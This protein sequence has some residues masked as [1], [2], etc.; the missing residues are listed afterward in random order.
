[1]CAHYKGY[2]TKSKHSFTLVSKPPGF[3]PWKQ[4]LLLVFQ[5]PAIVDEY[6][7]VVLFS[8]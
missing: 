1:M 8:K 3:H 5:Y 6:I 4:T 2:S 7:Y